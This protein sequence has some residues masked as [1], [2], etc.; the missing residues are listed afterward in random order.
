MLFAARAA[1]RPARL[2]YLTRS[3]AVTAFADDYDGDPDVTLHH[4]GGDP[5][6]GYDLAGLLA[7][8][9]GRAIMCCGPRALMEAVRARTAHWPA[10]SVRF[11]DFG[12]GS[13]AVART[14]RPFRA[15]LARSGGVVEVPAHV[16]L[17]DALRAAGHALPSNCESGSCGTCRTGLVSGAVDHRDLVLAEAER[18]GAIMPCV[19]RALGDE[20]VL[21][22]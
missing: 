22:L 6:R 18:A 17:L 15:R 20:L 1:G 16:S 11:E 8:P 4:D 12:A 13:A 2:V 3:R 9:A 19:S 5:A 10:G 21:D 14:N 7:E